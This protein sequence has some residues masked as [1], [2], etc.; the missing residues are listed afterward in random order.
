ML[1][2]DELVEIVSSD[3]IY[4]RDQWDQSIEDHSLRRASPI[5]RRLLVAEEMQRAWK[6]AGFEKQPQITASILSPG[7]LSS[8][9]KVRFASAGGALYGGMEIRGLFV[10]GEA[11]S[12]EQMKARALSG[13]PETTV[14]LVDFVAAPCLIVQGVKVSRRVL[15]KFVANK[16]GGAH[17]DAKRNEKVEGSLFRL[18]DAVI[19]ERIKIANKDAVYFELLSI[20]QALVR[21]PDIQGFI[22][23]TQGGGS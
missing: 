16:L 9:S 12:A 15:I 8:G 14:P 4:L 13:F 6:A 7:L 23:A 5:L 1:K 11:L 22:G 19:Q 10:Y 20:G 17:H 18:L 21:S 3:L 2:R